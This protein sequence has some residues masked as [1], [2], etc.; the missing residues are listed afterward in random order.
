MV[1]AMVGGVEIKAFLDSG[2]MVNA[3]QPALLEKVHYSGHKKIL[4]VGLKAVDGR[5][6]LSAKAT[7]TAPS[8]VTLTNFDNPTNTSFVSAPIQH[9]V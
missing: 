4:G 3:A 6:I 9:E 5:Q 8:L 7:F 1:K 2:E